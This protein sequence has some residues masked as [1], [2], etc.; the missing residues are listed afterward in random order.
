MVV[1]VA[2]VAGEDGWGVRRPQAASRPLPG[3]VI[4]MSQLAGRSGG[5]SPRDRSPPAPALVGNLEEVVAQDVT[6]GGAY[7]DADNDY[8]VAARP[9]RLPS[10]SVK[11][12]T[13]SPVGA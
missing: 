6:A 5:S 8:D 11:W 4:Q 2:D 1:L 10:G 13:T 12:P 9:I 7:N 3:Q